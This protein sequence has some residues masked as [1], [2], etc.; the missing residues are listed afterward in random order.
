MQQPMIAEVDITLEAHPFQVR[1][2]EINNNVED[3]Y[4]VHV[5]ILKHLEYQESLIVKL[6]AGV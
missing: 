6:E 2:Q 5:S 3:F 4:K 1:Q